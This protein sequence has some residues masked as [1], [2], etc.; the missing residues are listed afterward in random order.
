MPSKSGAA[1]SE[2]E[3]TPEMIEAGVAVLRAYEDFVELGPTLEKTLVCDILEDSLKTSLEVDSSTL[4]SQPITG[5]QILY[6]L[7]CLPFS[8]L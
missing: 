4:I 6:A 5:W 2:V 7:L 3:I 8:L 1:G